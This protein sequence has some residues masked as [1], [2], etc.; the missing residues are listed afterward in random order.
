MSCDVNKRIKATWWYYT[1]IIES[2]QVLDYFGNTLAH[3]WG[4]YPPS[5]RWNLVSGRFRATGS[6]CVS[7]QFTISFFYVNASFCLL[8]S[9][10]RQRAA[11]HHPRH[12]YTAKGGILKWKLITLNM[13]TNNSY[14]VGSIYPEYQ[15]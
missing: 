1:K 13:V 14:L 5:S 15:R 2:E 6:N 10:I 12:R 8:L 11:H 3:I 9:Q 4:T 7:E